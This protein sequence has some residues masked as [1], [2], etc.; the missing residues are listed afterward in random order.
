MRNNS[1]VAPGVAVPAITASPAGPTSAISKAGMT[2]SPLPTERG[3]T[4]NAGAVT[5]GSEASSPTPAVG[6]ATAAAAI[7]SPVFTGGC[8]SRGKPETNA[9]PDAAVSAR[10][11][12]AIR[13]IHVGVMVRNRW[14]KSLARQHPPKINDAPIGLGNQVRG[15]NPCGLR[16][17][18]EGRAASLRPDAV[19]EPPGTAS[20]AATLSRSGR[21]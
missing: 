17:S 1:T 12:M 18:P 15:P 6:A 19:I 20:V 9:A 2:S 13:P 3:G 11:R 5:R 4:P 21:S 8:L 16:R 10:S 7:A 14:P